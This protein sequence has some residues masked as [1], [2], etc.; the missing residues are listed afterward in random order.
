MYMYVITLKTF[1]PLN[2]LRSAW[3][4]VITL[5]IY[6]L[7]RDFIIIIIIISYLTLEFP[8]LFLSPSPYIV[9]SLNMI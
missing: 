4:G 8:S 2:R 1:K 5:N 3:R 9:T 7:Q 6:I